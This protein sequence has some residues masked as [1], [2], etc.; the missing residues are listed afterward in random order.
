L[1]NTSTIV[2][3]LDSHE[4]FD[5]I[6]ICNYV[7]QITREKNEGG[8]EMRVYTIVRICTRTETSFL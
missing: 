2:I 5:H 3:T 6:S 4:I 7:L 1:R 8:F